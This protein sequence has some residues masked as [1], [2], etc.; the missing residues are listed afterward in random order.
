LIKVAFSTINPLDRWQYEESK[1]EGLVLG[2]DGCGTIIKVSEGISESY[3]NK[4]VS[5]LGG[6][7]SKF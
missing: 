5:F 6:G 7:W 4:K 2:N 1:V 3:L